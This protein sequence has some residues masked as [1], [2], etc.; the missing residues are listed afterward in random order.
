MIKRSGTG[1]ATV[2]FEAGGHYANPMGTLYG[3]VLCDIAD[4]A[5]GVVY[6]S[7]L[8]YRWKQQL[9]WFCKILD[10]GLEDVKMHCATRPIEICAQ[11]GPME[12]V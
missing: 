9:D 10:G 11:T 7:T 1:G 6:R 3:G 4:A 8:R 5:M 2:E 12:H